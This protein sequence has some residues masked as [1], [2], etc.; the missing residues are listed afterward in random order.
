MYLKAAAAA[1]AGVVSRAPG[2]AR[3]SWPKTAA[4]PS[5]AEAEVQQYPR[6]SR[7]EGCLQ[8]GG[9]M[10]NMNMANIH[11]TMGTLQPVGNMA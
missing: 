4:S 3:E 2:D 11:L 5:T 8:T 7:L 1:V 9:D 6:A 10:A